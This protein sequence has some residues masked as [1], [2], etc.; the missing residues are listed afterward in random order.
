[1]CQKISNFYQKLSPIHIFKTIATCYI[2]PNG[3]NYTVFI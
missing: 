3:V 2:L 1:M